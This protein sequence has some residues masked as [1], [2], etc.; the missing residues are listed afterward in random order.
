MK[1]TVKITGTQ[2]DKKLTLV[3][4]ANRTDL[5]RDESR[6]FKEHLIN[7]LVE[8]MRKYGYNHS[9]IKIG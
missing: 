6:A 3:A 5:M 2:Y 1:N 4:K 8:V 7:D 9:E